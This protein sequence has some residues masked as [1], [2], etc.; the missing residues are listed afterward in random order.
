VQ[1]DKEQFIR[2]V[3]SQLQQIFAEI[4]GAPILGISAKNGYNVAKLLDLSWQTFNQWQTYLNTS[5][6]CIWLQ[7]AVKN[8]QPKLHKGISTK[9]KYATQIKSNPPTIAVFTNH[10]KAVVGNYQ[11]YLV[12]SL[13]EYFNLKLTPIRLVIRKSD[14][15][16]AN[17]KEKTFSKK[18]HGS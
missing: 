14:N 6:L 11:K 17:K 10:I 12:N 4:D 9:L 18:T 8:H 3:R 15:P 13:R 5:K 1:I 7:D 2:Q 16:F